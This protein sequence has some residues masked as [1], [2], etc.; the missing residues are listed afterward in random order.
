MKL[1]LDT[2][3]FYH[4][5]DIEGKDYVNKEEFDKV[6]QSS[7]ELGLSVL[8]LY[9]FFI[10]YKTQFNVVKQKMAFLK[11]NINSFYG[12]PRD[13]IVFT[14]EMLKNVILMKSKTDFDSFVAFVI[15]K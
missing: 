3:A 9:E 2:N 1:I 12:Y 15:K 11:G 7:D 10:R 8:S 5:A 4:W 14:N 6:I 13:G